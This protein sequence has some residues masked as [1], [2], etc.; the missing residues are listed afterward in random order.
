VSKIDA[1]FC[2]VDLFPVLA[3]WLVWGM[4]DEFFLWL[5]TN[6]QRE[7][8]VCARLESALRGFMCCRG[9]VPWWL[10]FF[11]GLWVGE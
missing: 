6:E 10:L 3:G 11:P 9:F 1:K 8:V 4:G 5:M 7:L 2:L